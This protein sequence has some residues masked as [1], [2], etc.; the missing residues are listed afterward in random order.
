VYFTQ[1]VVAVL[2][3]LEIAKKA[4]WAAQA[5]AATGMVMADL[6]A[7]KARQTAQII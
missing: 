3:N 6:G 2:H 1:V 4:A 7:L 5:A